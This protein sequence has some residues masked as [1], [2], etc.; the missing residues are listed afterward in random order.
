[1]VVIVFGFIYRLGLNTL[2]TINKLSQDVK[3]VEYGTIEDKLAG[4]AIVLKK[5]QVTL[6]QAE[7]RF[8]NII[9]EGGKIGKGSIVGYFVN[10]Q[11]QTP[12]RAQASGIY[13]RQTDGLEEVLRDINLQTVSPEVFKYQTH[14]IAA[15]Q[16][17]LAGQAVYKIVDNLEPT[18]ILI[19]FPLN[20]VDFD[21][22]ITEQVNVIYHGKDL[23]KARIIE[24]KSDFD[25]LLLILEFNHFKDELLNQRYIELEL[26]FDSQSGFMLPN[27]SIV[28][29]D[30]KKGILLANGE[31]I[32]FRSIKIIKTKRDISIVEGLNKSDLVANNPHD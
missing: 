22:E 16:A 26:V 5:E 7:G 4:T 6:A 8:E 17:I 23:G 11:G 19:Q 13:M 15:E 28:E 9:Q 25:Q 3:A 21:V 14:K 2:S 31:D 27:K 29:R 20:K 32:S 10:S 24:M 18:R 1:M 12:L 30:G